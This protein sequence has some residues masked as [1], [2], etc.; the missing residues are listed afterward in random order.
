[1]AA[2]AADGKPPRVHHGQHILASPLL[3]TGASAAAA[4]AA[5]THVPAALSCAA[6]LPAAPSGQIRS[7]FEAIVSP[8]A[9]ALD[10]PVPAL[11]GGK[12]PSAG[13]SSKSPFEASGAMLLA[14][15]VGDGPGMGLP[16]GAAT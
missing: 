14:D 3:G 9:A 12:L 10:T 1:M 8:G 11:P 4:A 5:D 6:A 16:A 2:A 7:P 13:R 15:L